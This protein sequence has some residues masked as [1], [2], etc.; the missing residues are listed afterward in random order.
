MIRRQ[1][2]RPMVH[3]VEVRS[4]IGMHAR[5]FANQTSEGP[6][7]G[8][9]NIIIRPREVHSARF[10]GLFITKWCLAGPGLGRC[11]L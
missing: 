8:T 2:S 1:S 3:E 9:V 7:V 10:L 4:A 6:H 5:S 11:R